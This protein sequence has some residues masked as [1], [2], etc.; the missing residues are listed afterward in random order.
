MRGVRDSSSSPNGAAPSAGRL[1][2]MIRN[3]SGLTRAQL[4]A[5]TGMS[6]TTLTERLDQLS[7]AGLVHEARRAAGT[8]GRPAKIIEFDDTG[9]VV[10]ALDLGHTR[11]RVAA[12]S[13]RAEP[14]AHQEVVIDVTRAPGP[15]LDRMLRAAADVLSAM[16]GVRPVGVGMAVP[17]PVDVFGRTDWSTSPMRQW[18]NDI[19]G[20][21]VRRRFPV[22]LVLENDARAMAIGEASL[23]DT[24]DSGADIVM[25]ITYGSGIGA[26]IVVDGR[27]LRG[28]TGAAGDIGHVRMRA[29]GPRC[30]CGRRGCLA[31]YASGRALLRTLRPR[32][33]RSVADVLE[34]LD[35]RDPQVRAVVHD[36]ATAVGLVVGGA[37]QGVNPRTLVLGGELGSHPVVARTIER[38][39]RLIALPRVL[40]GTRITTTRLGGDA[41]VVGM[42]HLVIRHLYDA[43]AV[44]R[45]LAAIG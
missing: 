33:V 24:D 20:S 35:A 31:A 4:Q 42:A 32:G 21:A 39:V 19:I 14:L 29:D 11:C 34:L 17:A 15:T 38:R 40:S 44:D 27:P 12:V 7:A 25:A 8:G 37:M 6:R 2:Q 30:R 10:L 43:E 9:K 45:R 18:T 1:L 22:P 28:S 41:G 26:G 16:P 23:E 3:G 36:A 13:L 5:G